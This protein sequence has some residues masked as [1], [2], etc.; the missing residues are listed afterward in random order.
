MASTVFDSTLLKAKFRGCLIGVLVGDCLG[1]PFEFEGY[2]I[3]DSVKIILPSKQRLGGFMTN[4]M[5]GGIFHTLFHLLNYLFPLD[6][7]YNPFKSTK[8][9]RYTDDTCMT[10]NVV[11]SLVDQG[12][13]NAKDIAER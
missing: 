3:N 13:V 5:N 11:E 2:V 9:F 1:V 8:K 4:L 7:F 12:E 6:Y 10:L